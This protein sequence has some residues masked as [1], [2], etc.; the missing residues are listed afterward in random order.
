MSGNPL[1]KIIAGVIMAIV[2]FVI[3]KSGRSGDDN[4]EAQ[5]NPPQTQEEITANLQEID[6]ATPEFSDEEI[7]LDDRTLQEDFSADLDTEEAVMKEL[8]T[9]FKQIRVENARLA[10]E[11]REFKKK[12]QQML[13][14]EKNIQQRVDRQLESVEVR[15]S[16]QNAQL[17]T[18]LEESRNILDG[19]KVAYDDLNLNKDNTSP[20]NVDGY[21]LNG[22]ENGSLGYDDNG[23]PIDNSELVWQL[24]LDAQQTA[25]GKMRLPS[26]SMDK[27]NFTAPV[28]A[29]T[30]PLGGNKEKKTKAERSIKAYTIPSNASLF[31]SVSMTALLGRIPLDGVVQQPYPFKLLIGEDNLS[32]NGISI[33]NLVGI[34]M[35]G[36]AS[37][38]WNLSC[39]SGEIT[40]MT[41]T[42]ADGTIVS[43]PEKDEELKEPLGWFSD[44]NGIPCVSGE[45][46]SNGAT[47]LSQRI[48]LGAI[49]AWA[50]AKTSA[51][52]SRTT[53]SL[54]GTTSTLTG[55]PLVAAR[56]QAISGGVGEVSEWLRERQD[57]AFDAVY[58]APGTPVIVHITEE[59]WVD[60]DP[61]GRR[62]QHQ[63]NFNS[64]PVRTL[65]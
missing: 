54:G 13:L 61:E 5:T 18:S 1:L 12:M 52:Y 15:S 33:P 14:M 48:G 6:L 28:D 9:E 16:N 45:K 56:N 34:K 41:F 36:H 42:F 30:E 59:I 24:P 2:V 31:G 23:Q 21:T 10:E 55:D 25:D 7:I 19:L 51:E 35:S 58:V 57:Q 29:L 63:E 49:E 65:D 50:D 32:S 60:Y 43:L 26:I 37:G 11:N 38:D 62:V 4:V 47:Y 53:N 64:I 27:I 8:L 20:T 40:S 22:F 39:V 46:I 44:A 17:Q 3:V